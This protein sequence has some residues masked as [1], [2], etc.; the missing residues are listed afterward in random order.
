MG[1]RNRIGEI[2]KEK[3]LTHLQVAES[4]GVSRQAV[5]K[6]ATG[7]PPTLENLQKLAQALSVSVSDL[8]NAEEDRDDEDSAYE[9]GFVRALEREPVRDGWTRVPMLDVSGSCGYGCN[10]DDYVEIVGAAD[11][12]NSFLR[13]LPGVAGLGEHFEIINAHGDSMEPTIEKRSFCLLDRNQNRIT[14]DAI[15]C[16]Q[17]QNDIFIKRVMRNFDGSLTLISDNPKY[18]PQ[19]VPREALD[20]ARVLGRVIFVFNGKE[21]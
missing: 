4:I 6:W 1:T 7:T 11:F 10:C 19:T 16:I 9:K 14:M 12:S 5:Q 18:P 17:T 2:I 13:S 8:L 3:G 15:F 20:S 21:L